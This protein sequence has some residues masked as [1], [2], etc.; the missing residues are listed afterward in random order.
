ML[1]EA[2]QRFD[3]DGF[4]ILRGYLNPE[5]VHLLKAGFDRFVAEIA[6]GLDKRE[7]MYEDYSDSSTIKQSN[8]LGLEPTL[9]AWQSQGKIHDLAAAM[10]GP[11][12]PQHVEYFDKPVGRNHETPAHQD[13]Y[14][15]C[16]RPNEACTVWIPLSSVEAD[17]GALVYIKGSHKLGVREH[18]A[19]NLLGFSQ[20]LIEDPRSLGEAVV[21]TVE[22]GDVLV[23]HSLTVHYAGANRSQ[24]RRPVIA[25]TY[26]SAS[27]VKDEEAKARYEAA[28]LRQHTAKGLVT[29]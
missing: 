9:A 4:A 12:S 14:Y 22:P 16:L 29:A 21:C 17:N 20:G 18:D 2:K 28:L 11:V 23:H 25:Y 15:F 19:S 8:A 27:A 3:E 6:P 5:E 7:V 26:F 24:R 13:G 10:I 1:A